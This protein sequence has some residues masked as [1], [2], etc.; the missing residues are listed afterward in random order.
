MAAFILKSSFNSALLACNGSWQ[1]AFLHDD[2]LM[3]STPAS[4]MQSA[5]FGMIRSS[6]IQGAPSAKCLLCQNEMTTAEPDHVS[7]AASWLTKVWT[8]H[9]TTNG[10]TQIEVNRL[11]RIPSSCPCTTTFSTH[12]SAVTQVWDVCSTF[13]STSEQLHPGRVCEMLSTNYEHG[14]R[15]CRVVIPQQ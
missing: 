13:C 5:S 8:A 2:S 7:L 12:A 1:H 15:G 6:A 4:V 10:S 14:S 9:H 11:L 3:S